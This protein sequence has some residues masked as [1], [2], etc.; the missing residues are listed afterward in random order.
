M[1]FCFFTLR[2]STFNHMHIC[3]TTESEIRKQRYLNKTF[4]DRRLI[5]KF[6]L[7]WFDKST[8][9]KGSRSKTHHL[10]FIPITLKDPIEKACGDIVSRIKTV[11]TSLQS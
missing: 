4:H 6:E 11:R 8:F 3:S 2:Y 9:S 1:Q 10:V 7:Q 5:E